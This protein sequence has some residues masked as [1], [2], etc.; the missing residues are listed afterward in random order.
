[1][2]HTQT[3]LLYLH[4]MLIKNLIILHPEHLKVM[5][6]KNIKTQTYQEI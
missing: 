4:M 3:E 6:F 1:M 5:Y 2:A